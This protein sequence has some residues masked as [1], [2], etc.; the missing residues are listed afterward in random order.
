MKSWKRWL[1][2]GAVVAAT[3]GVWS[4]RRATACLLGSC[5]ALIVANQITQIAQMVTQLS[6]MVTQV[7]SL[8]G[9]L[10]TADQALGMTQQLVQSDDVGMGNIG[11]MRQGVDRLQALELQGIGLSSSASVVGAYNQRVPGVT[12]E[13]GWLGVLANA[14][15]ALVSGAFGSWAVPDGAGREVLQGLQLVA[16]G[17][18][19][20]Q[21]QWA[22]LEAQAPAVLSEVDVRALTAD[23]AAQD[24]LVAWHER[25]EAAASARL[26]HTH[27]EAV[28]ASSMV[29]LTE[30][31]QRVLEETRGDDQMR[32]QRLQQAML[33]VGVTETELRLAQAQLTA[34]Q[35]ARETRER[36]AAE[37]ARREARER[38]R[39][40]LLLARE[41]QEQWEAGLEDV[42]DDL[43]ESYRYV[44]STTRW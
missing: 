19:S 1:I 28:A 27:A 22:D 20:Y 5:D 30:E 16:S 23:P 43:V 15:T 6:H 24:R 11:R 34:Y 38:W 26:V 4:E 7:G 13:A 18:G 29:A 33:T 25:A 12:D 32:I 3:A 10:G 17:V 21:E 42:G 2:V 8:S 14:E 41:T 39:T 36:Y 37:A 35:A 44:P 31:V 40:D 9:I